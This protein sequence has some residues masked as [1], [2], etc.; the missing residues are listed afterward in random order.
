MRLNL[1]AQMKP[2]NNAQ[3]HTTAWVSWGL[4]FMEYCCPADLQL[5]IVHVAHV[6]L[7]DGN[8]K[9]FNRWLGITVAG[10][11]IFFLVLQ[12]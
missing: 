9:K 8:R 12:V 10:W 5:Y 7:K 11:V 2:L 3:W 1:K 6:A 4:P